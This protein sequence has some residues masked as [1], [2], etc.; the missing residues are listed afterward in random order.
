MA[1]APKLLKQ[2]S[3]QANST[4]S[5]TDVY[6]AASPQSLTKMATRHGYARLPL[7]M[8][9]THEYP[10]SLS[11]CPNTFHY[12]QPSAAWYVQARAKTRL[13]TSPDISSYS[14]TTTSRKPHSS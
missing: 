10:G 7:V 5:S 3:L 12:V 1:R 4:S 2:T 6:A 11:R 9:T 13:S 8:R 14:T